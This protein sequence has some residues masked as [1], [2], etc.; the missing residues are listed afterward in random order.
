MQLASQSLATIARFAGITPATH[1][2]EKLAGIVCPRCQRFAIDC[3]VLTKHQGT[4]VR[5]TITDERVGRTR[6]RAA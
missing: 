3:A 2:R 4:I 6:E 1:E 5:I